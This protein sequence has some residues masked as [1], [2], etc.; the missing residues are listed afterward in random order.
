MAQFDAKKFAA[1]QPKKDNQGKEFAGREAEAQAEQKEEVKEAAPVPE[2]DMG[3][4]E[5]MKGTSK[6]LL[7][8]NTDSLLGSIN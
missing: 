7:L 5:P 4:S 6:L 8:R 1:S 2:K 3:D